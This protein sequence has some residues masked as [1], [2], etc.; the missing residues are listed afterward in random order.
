[1]QKSFSGPP[2]PKH[3]K[4]ESAVDIRQPSCVKSV[5]LFQKDETSHERK[6]R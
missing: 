4:Q 3:F 5:I 1:M 6:V 2:A